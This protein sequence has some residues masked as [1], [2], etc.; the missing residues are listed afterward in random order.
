LLIFNFLLLHKIYVGAENLT[1]MT[2]LEQLLENKGTVSSALSKQLAK[3]TL[4]GD[5]S[6]L[7]E[8]LKLVHYDS[9]VVRSGAAKIIEKVA[10]E[11]PE[12]VAPFLSELATCFDYNE[13]QTK[14]MMIHTF[15]LCAKLQPSVARDVF[16]MVIK[17]LNP[18]YGTCLR[19]RSITY[20]GYMGSVSKND[21]D[22]CFPLL[23][24]SFNNHPDRI[25]RIFESLERLSFH[26]DKA[27]KQ[28][29]NSYV[30]KYSN[31]K[32]PEIVKWTKKIRKKLND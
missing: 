4:A 27:Q 29:V 13:P 18:S 1:F 10:E 12:L 9:K 5:A 8:A 32:S 30:E 17:Y 23:I 24:D 11:K 16:E 19:D 31:S 20:L 6:I 25:T 14:W 3:D 7:D 21:S 28:I 26:F 2:L 22:L 15:G